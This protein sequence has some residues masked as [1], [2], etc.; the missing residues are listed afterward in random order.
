M[1][2]RKRG[3][4]RAAATILPGVTRRA[5]ARRGF[6]RTA[7][8][9]EWPAIVGDAL[10]AETIPERL[11]FPRGGRAGG[12]LHIRVGGAFATELQ[13]L[14]PLVIERINRHF[15]YAAVA[16]LAIV[17]GPIRARRSPPAKK[18][19]PMTGQQERFVRN[20]VSRVGDEPLRQALTKL[21]EAVLTS[22]E[23]PKE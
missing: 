4:M 17:Q 7:V 8:V 11:V 9:T 14:E 20:R 6:S 21:G 22:R 10:A 2:E 15:G 16:R 1:T 3:G 19:R 13:H 12:T 5:F 23:R 18:H